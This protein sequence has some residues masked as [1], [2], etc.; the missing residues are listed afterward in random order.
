MRRNA[1]Y[2]KAVRALEATLVV[3]VA[4]N[5]LIWRAVLGDGATARIREVATGQAAPAV[6]VPAAWTVFGRTDGGIDAGE[7]EGA[8]D[9]GSGAAAAQAQPRT[10]APVAADPRKEAAGDAAA[11]GG[12]A[13]GGFGVPV[14]I[15]IP[16]IAL[17]AAVEK[18]TLA[19]DGSMGVPRRPRDAAWYALGPRPG[20]A[21]SATIA[22]HLDWINGASAVFADLHKLRPGDTV[23]VKDANGSVVFFVVRESRRYD[24]A[25]DAVDVFSSNDGKAHLNIVTCDGSWDKG[26]DQ[27][28][29]RLVVFTD[30][31]NE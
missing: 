4:C 15:S 10:G 9:L 21:G 12:A 7:T 13:H 1:K 11:D 17:D 23:A 27:Y 3:L 26:S 2:H 16:R 22:G 29:K 19:A 24:A 5:V 25:A 30:K 14:H 18:V 20:E 31:V 6:V 28:T 8:S